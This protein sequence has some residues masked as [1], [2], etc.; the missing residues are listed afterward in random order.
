MAEASRAWLEKIAP[1][2]Q[3]EQSIHG[4]AAYRRYATSCYQQQ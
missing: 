1:E 3:Y 4:L 2:G